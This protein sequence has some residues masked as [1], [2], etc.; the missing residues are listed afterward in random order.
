MATKTRPPKSSS[1]CTTA[2]RK[3][4]NPML[5]HLSIQR[6]SPEPK[7][8]GGAAQVT[9]VLRDRLANR[10]RFE[11]FE[12]QVRGVAR[13]RLVLEKQIVD[14]ERLAFRHDHG[15]LDGVDELADVSRPVVLLQSRNR[16]G[17]DR[18]PSLAV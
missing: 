5:R 16:V 4:L 3:V 9:R 18:E 7:I 15:A 10:A 11:V 1:R 17:R 6:R 8:A 13:R 12:I 2:R 14:A